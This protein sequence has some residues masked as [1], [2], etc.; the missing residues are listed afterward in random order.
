MNPDQPLTA[1]LWAWDFEQLNAFQLANSDIV[2][3]HDYEDTA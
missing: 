1:G 2:T 3:Y